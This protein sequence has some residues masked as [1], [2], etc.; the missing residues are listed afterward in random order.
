MKSFWTKEDHG[1]M[2]NRT[3]TKYIQTPLSMFSGPEFEELLAL[4]AL[5]PEGAHIAGGAVANAIGGVTD[6]NS[7]IDIFFCNFSAFDVTYK[8][9]KEKGFQTATDLNPY[10][11]T[12]AVVEMEHPE[13][14]K[15]QLIKIIWHDDATHI[16]DLFD[17]TVCQF[18]LDVDRVYYNSISV[19][20]L[21]KKQ[22]NL[23]RMLPHSDIVY[24]LVKYGA[25]GYKITPD[26]G[27]RIAKEIRECLPV[28]NN[29]V[30]SNTGTEQ[31]AQTF[32]EDAYSRRPRRRSNIFT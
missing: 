21:F 11:V 7:D 12:T 16:I 9:L 13:S 20:D 26:S 5:L 15:I 30:A 3:A 25:K 27:K 6:P 8:I 17:F 18:V 22:L 1:Y 4:N 28:I 32:T 23:H 29:Q 10:D 2:W 19:I 31:I 14:P 24:R